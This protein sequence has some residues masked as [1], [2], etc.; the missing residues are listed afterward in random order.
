MISTHNQVTIIW[1]DFCLILRDRTQS[2]R[3]HSTQVTRFST[4]GVD[5]EFC[6]DSPSY[7]LAAAP[8]QQPIHLPLARFPTSLPLS[9]RQDTL[10]LC[11]YLIKKSCYTAIGACTG[12]TQHTSK[13]LTASVIKKFSMSETEN[14]CSRLCHPSSQDRRYQMLKSMICSSYW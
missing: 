1:K 3:E 5:A 12:E 13:K 8:A 11:L 6:W 4:A 2:E 7:S 9:P 10:G 14:S